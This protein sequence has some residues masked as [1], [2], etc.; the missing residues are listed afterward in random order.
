L[1]IRA[2]EEGSSE[3]RHDWEEGSGPKVRSPPMKY[4]IET[5]GMGTRAS[6]PSADHS[7][8]GR[9]NTT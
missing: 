9:S 4:L 5:L 7:S 6:D 8:S 1:V 2:T 3:K